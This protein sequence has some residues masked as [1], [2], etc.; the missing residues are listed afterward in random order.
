MIAIAEY[1]SNMAGFI[2]N[3]E[4]VIESFKAVRS[5]TYSL[6][7]GVGNLQ[8]ALDNIDARISQEETKKNAAVQVHKKSNDFL[9][10][11]IR[12]DKDVA[13]LVDKNRDQFYRVHPWLKPASISEEE[14][15]WYKKA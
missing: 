6:S 2:S 10:L 7:G 1:Q 9:D 14:K 3:T 4:S 5:E 13:K 12:V 15:P 8:G 11:A